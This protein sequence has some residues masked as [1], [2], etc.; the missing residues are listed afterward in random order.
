MCSHSGR[1]V[2]ASQVFHV[3]RVYVESCS[4]RDHELDLPPIEP[5]CNGPQKCIFVRVVDTCAGC[6]H[7]SKHVDLTKS[8]FSSI[9]KLDQ[10]RLDNINMREATNPDEW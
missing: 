10:G 2:W 4:I 6:A 7:G 5:V 3:H 8:A 9:A 1:L